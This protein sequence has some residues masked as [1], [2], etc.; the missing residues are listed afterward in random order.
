M[1]ITNVVL[2]LTLYIITNVNVPGLSLCAQ[3]CVQRVYYLC[4][5]PG[6]EINEFCDCV[7]AAGKLGN[8]SFAADVRSFLRLRINFF[9]DT[10]TV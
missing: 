6:Y 5:V 3:Y 7:G 1:R 9:L 10:E 8:T 4:Y 2:F